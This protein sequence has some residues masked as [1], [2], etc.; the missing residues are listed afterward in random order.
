MKPSLPC[1]VR[2]A[3]E[4]VRVRVSVE[5]S[6]ALAWNACDLLLTK[7]LSSTTIVPLAV[8]CVSMRIPSDS[9]PS[10]LSRIVARVT[11]TVKEPLWL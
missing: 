7:S 8:P 10:L 11:L 3:V 1:V 4:F 5:L 2:V 6:S 9:E